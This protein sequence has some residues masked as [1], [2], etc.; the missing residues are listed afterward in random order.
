MAK[1]QVTGCAGAHGED[2]TPCYDCLAWTGWKA[3]RKHFNIEHCENT[4]EMYH[5]TIQTKEV[6]R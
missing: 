4:R 1:I 2:F 3:H 6:E 5:L